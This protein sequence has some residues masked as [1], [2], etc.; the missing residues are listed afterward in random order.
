M[1]PLGLKGAPESSNPKL[2]LFDTSV[3]LLTALQGANDEKGPSD[4]AV[5]LWQPGCCRDAATFGFKVD[6]DS[7]FIAA[8]IHGHVLRDLP[9]RQ[10][11][12]GRVVIRKGGAS[13]RC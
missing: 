12:N 5:G 13:E 7:G 6:F 9:Q 8:C 4:P 2:A 10:I 1:L 11:A 3:G